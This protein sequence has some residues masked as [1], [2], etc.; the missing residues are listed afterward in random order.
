MTVNLN[1]LRL[2]AA[3]QAQ[4]LILTLRAHVTNGVVTIPEEEIAEKANDILS[5]TFSLCGVYQEDNPDFA[6]VSDRIGDPDWWEA[7]LKEELEATRGRVL[8]SLDGSVVSDMRSS[9]ETHE[10]IWNAYKRYESLGVWDDY[11]FS[12]CPEAEALEAEFDRLTAENAELRRQRDLYAERWEAELKKG[13][14]RF[15]QQ[16]DLDR[17][18]TGKPS[19]NEIQDPDQAYEDWRD[20]ES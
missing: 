11:D 4:A 2:N 20:E 10:A 6:D 12:H 1:G 9:T 5:S 13:D 8:V 17:L 3:R 7:E 14:E 18:Y 19:T 16:E 15:T